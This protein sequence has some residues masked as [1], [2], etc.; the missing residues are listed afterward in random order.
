[1]AKIYKTTVARQDGSID[2]PRELDRGALQALLTTLAIGDR[3]RVE[4]V[5]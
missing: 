4:R 1:M 2:I 5:R 3:L